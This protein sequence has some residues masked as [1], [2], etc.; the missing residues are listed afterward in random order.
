M[1]NSAPVCSPAC[2]NSDG[3]NI[4]RKL[5]TESCDVVDDPVPAGNSIMNGYA[6]ANGVCEKSAESDSDDGCNGL[7]DGNPIHQLIVHCEQ[8]GSMALDLSR[9]GLRSLCHKLLKLSDLQVIW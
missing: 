8:T 6:S 9:R 5:S 4:S 2:V 1:M 3:G 7:S